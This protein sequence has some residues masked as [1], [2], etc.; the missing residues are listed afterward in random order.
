MKKILLII[1]SLIFSLGIGG[2]LKN[3]QTQTNN[4]QEQQKITPVEKSEKTN[5]EAINCINDYKQQFENNKNGY[6]AG[7][8]L[9]TFVRGTT[10]QE[11]ETIISAH[12]LSIDELGNSFLKNPWALINVPQGKEIELACTI[13]QDKKIQSAGLNT[14]VS[15]H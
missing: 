13:S 1:I 2:C 11:A 8:I 5:A 7:K 9:I 14:T 4:L 3:N 15:T 10:K 6:Q 12:E